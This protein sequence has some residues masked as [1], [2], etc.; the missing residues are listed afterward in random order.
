MIKG[1][2]AVKIFRKNFRRSKQKSGLEVPQ[3]S[4]TFARQIQKGQIVFNR[5]VLSN[6]HISSWHGAVAGPVAGP[7]TYPVN[8]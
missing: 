6:L 5:A 8:Q 3:G 1:T 4:K 7:N 2:S